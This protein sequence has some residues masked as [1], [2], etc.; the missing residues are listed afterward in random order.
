MSEGTIK[1][2]ATEASPRLGVA[3]G[4]P[5]VKAEVLSTKLATDVLGLD[6]KLELKEPLTKTGKA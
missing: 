5:L 1:V 3:Q 4:G 2:V 6:L